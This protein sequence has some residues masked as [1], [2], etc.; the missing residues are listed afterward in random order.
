MRNVPNEVVLHKVAGFLL[1]VGK[2]KANL[3]LKR[4]NGVW[5]SWELKP[6]IVMGTNRM[7]EIKYDYTPSFYFDVKA[8]DM[9]FFFGWGVF[10]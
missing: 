9:R 6:V 4:R 7:R 2:F 8:S 5:H 10:C 1:N 3:G